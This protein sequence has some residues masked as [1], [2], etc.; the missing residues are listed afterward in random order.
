[1]SQAHDPE[2]LGVSVNDITNSL[3]R[4]TKFVRSLQLGNATEQELK[5]WEKDAPLAKLKNAR[6]DIELAQLMLATGSRHLLL[7][8][9][10]LFQLHAIINKNQIEKDLFEDLSRWGAFSGAPQQ[11]KGPIDE[12]IDKSLLHQYIQ[13]IHTNALD[14]QKNINELTNS[15]KQTHPDLK[16]EITNLTTVVD[17]IFSAH[18]DVNSNNFKSLCNKIDNIYN[19]GDGKQR[20]LLKTVLFGM[21]GLY[22]QQLALN[23]PSPF[24]RYGIS[25]KPKPKNFNDMNL[26]IQPLKAKFLAT[27]KPY[28]AT[29]EVHGTAIGAITED[30]N[31]I[32][33]VFNATSRVAIEIAKAFPNEDVIDYKGN[34]IQAPRP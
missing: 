11:L 5:N 16:R 12:E 24:K 8:M 27:L 29:D 23:K 2:Y 4:A 28:F 18:I 31:H 6:N 9:N 13:I 19:Q 22:N 21:S 10:D 33:L 14:R 34:K 3:S 15:L 30:Y 1:M 17:Q 7:R 32:G 26:A 20:Q 25:L